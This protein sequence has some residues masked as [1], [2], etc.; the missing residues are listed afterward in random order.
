MAETKWQQRE[1][2]RNA[3]LELECFLGLPL[4]NAWVAS[5]VALALTSYS[6]T[7]TPLKLIGP[8]GMERCIV[9]DLPSEILHSLGP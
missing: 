7:K 2:F 4:L 6:R 1:G 9:Y 8:H 3:N 5:Q